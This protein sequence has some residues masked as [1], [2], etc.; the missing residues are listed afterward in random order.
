MCLFVACLMGDLMIERCA[1]PI[2]TSQ[3]ST[4]TEGGQGGM[5]CKGAPYQEEANSC[6]A[7]STTGTLDGMSI[8]VLR[9]VTP[10]E[11]TGK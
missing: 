9:K 4:I 10:H 8:L 1:S 7:D 3:I 5:P 11:G 2:F 6:R